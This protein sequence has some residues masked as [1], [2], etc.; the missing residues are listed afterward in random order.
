M[1]ISNQVTG[2]LQRSARGVCER[3]CE[4][5]GARPVAK[6]LGAFEGSGCYYCLQGPASH[7]PHARV[8]E[9]K[10]LVLDDIISTNPYVTYHRTH[11]I[12]SY[13]L[14]L[15]TLAAATDRILVLPKIMSFQRSLLVLLAGGEV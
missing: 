5:A 8:V 2:P 12:A 6:R 9:R 4:H 15:V 3:A 10:Y 14:Q 13:L 1:A 7:A 11:F